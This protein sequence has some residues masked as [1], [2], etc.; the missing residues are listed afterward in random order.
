MIYIF[1]AD[2]FEEVE[3]LAPLDLLR[4]AKLSVTLVGVTG[5]TVTGAHN[6]KV[7]CDDVIEN[8][9][10]SDE[11][12]DM[13]VLPGG[14][15][16]ADNLRES[17]LVQSFITRAENDG[18]FITAI[19]A[20]PRILGERGLLKGKKATCYPGFEKYLEGAETNGDRVVRDGRIITGA[21]MGAAVD[22]GLMLIEAL[23][24]KETSENI[25]RGIIA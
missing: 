9:I 21:G 4:R 22:F 17:D 25:R 2:G 1:L 13:I 18:A 11:K 12:I 24:S 8:V 14:L 23:T 6:I 20:A 15:P 10:T 16:G 5:K 7:E 19:C 3:A